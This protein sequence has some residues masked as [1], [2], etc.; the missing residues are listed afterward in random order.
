[1]I[2]AKTKMPKIPKSCKDCTF[3]R[4]V[5]TKEKIDS[6][7]RYK[8]LCTLTGAKCPKRKEEDGYTRFFHPKWCPLFEMEDKDEIQ[9]RTEG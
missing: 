4:V 1:M 8:R 6:W 7:K 2:C 9:S 3:S 5:D